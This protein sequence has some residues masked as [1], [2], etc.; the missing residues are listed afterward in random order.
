MVA[1]GAAQPRADPAPG[2]RRRRRGSCRRSSRSRSL[3]FVVWALVG[4]GAAPGARAG[5]RGRRADHRLPVRARPGDADVDHG[6]H[7]PRRARPACCSGTPRRSSVCEKV[8][9]LV[10]DKTGTLTE[11][12]PQLVA[13]RRRA[14]ATRATLLRLAAS[15]ERASEHPLAAA[16]V[17]GAARARHRSCRRVDGLRSR[18]RQGRR[19][20]ASTGTQVALG[21]AALLRGAR[22]STSARSPRAPRTLRARRPDGDVRRASTAAP[23]GLLGVA[24]PIKAID[25]GG[26]RA[27]CTPTAC[28]SSCSP[29]TAARPREAVARAAR[30]RR[31]ERRGAAASDK[32]RGR[33]AA[34]ARGPRRR[35]GRRRHQRRAG[36][37]AA[38]T[39]ASRWAPAPTS[40]WR[41]PASRS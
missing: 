5:Q 7:R 8:D 14:D 23:A 1:R 4:P 36:A 33:R 3:T 12:K 25:A 18:H 6:R 24:D 35:D 27:R 31:G 40:R 30:H 15:L 37:R 26:A 32:A 13:R 19:R 17:A 20:R 21:N 22:R 2:R 9:T 39:S 29:A 34:A 41:A 11:G 16:I 28:A 10:V 38:R